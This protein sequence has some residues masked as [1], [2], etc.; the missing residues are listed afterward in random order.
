MNAHK[1]IGNGPGVDEWANQFINE[2][3]KNYVL[4]EQ[5]IYLSEISLIF[6]SLGML[7]KRNYYLCSAALLYSD[8][9]PDV[10]RMFLNYIKDTTPKL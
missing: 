3:L 7:R 2:S 5:V 6:E 1:E 9:K 4:D 10:S 8:K